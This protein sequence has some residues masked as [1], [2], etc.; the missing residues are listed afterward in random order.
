MR[1]T[2]GA[3]PA[4]ARCTAAGRYP[5]AR[6]SARDLHTHFSRT[7]GRVPDHGALAIC[8]GNSGVWA[9]VLFGLPTRIFPANRL[10]WRVDVSFGGWSGGVAVL[11]WRCRSGWASCRRIWPRLMR[12]WAIGMCWARSSG[13]GIGRAR[14]RS[15]IARATFVRLM[16]IK[17]RTGWGYETLVRE[18]SDSVHLRRFCL[19]SLAQRVAHE[20][21]VRKLVRRLGPDVVDEITREPIGAAQRER[22][23]VARAVRCD[24][25][26]VEA[27]IRDPSDAGLAVDSARVLAAEGRHVARLVGDRARRVRDRS[28]RGGGCG[29]SAGRSRGGVG[30]PTPSCC[31]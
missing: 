20:S 28:R 1:R 8:P 5:P 7:R 15:T 16:V 11:I 14:S 9:V 2:L 29:R 22:R 21:T 19:I 27:D 4:P 10:V 12:C 13:R 25:T 3:G 31:A 18:V 26:V 6:R 17:Q 23:F 24:S 30:R